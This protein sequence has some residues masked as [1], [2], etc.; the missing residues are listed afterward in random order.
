MVDQTLT[1]QLVGLLGEDAVHTGE[2]MSRHTTFKVGGPA[3]LFIEP[4]DI[5]GVVESLRLCREAGIDVHVLG[6]GSNVLVSD[7]GMGG[8]VMHL[9]DAFSNITILDTAVY[10][11]AGATNADVSDLACMAGLAGFEFAC[12]IPGSIGGA[13]IM[14]AGAYGGEFKDVCTTVICLTPGLEIRYVSA[15][16]A[17]WGYRRSMM[18]DKGYIVLG[19]VLE[20]AHADPLDIQARIDDLTQRR[21]AKQP[22]DMAS[23]GS[24]FKRPEGRFAGQLIEEAGMRG[25]RSG[26]AMVSDLHCGF[27]VN[28]GSATAA[29]VVRVMDDVRA[30]VFDDSGVELEPE[31]RMWGF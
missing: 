25:Y 24:T 17:D 22:L 23:A 7:E 21:A 4:S 18:S 28:T 10:A 31:V 16:E 3:E 1:A 20:L 8:A 13:A 19:A 11:E 6:C 5:E 14:N 27:V 29:D 30:A 15:G 26:G 2:P 12:G 9:G